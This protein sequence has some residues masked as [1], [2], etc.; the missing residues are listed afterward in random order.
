[1]IDFFVVFGPDA[2]VLAQTPLFHLLTQVTSLLPYVIDAPLFVHSQFILQ[3]RYQSANQLPLLPQ[4][5]L[6]LRQNQLLV[7]DVFK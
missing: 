6:L 1:M 5:L 3:T 7:F 4:I 2:A